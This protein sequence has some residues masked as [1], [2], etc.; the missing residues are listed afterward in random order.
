M[1]D[2]YKNHDI[3]AYAGWVSDD[4]E[5]LSCTSGGIASALSRKMI[6]NGG[7]VAGVTYT[8]G[9]YKA[10]YEIVNDESQ[11]YKF[12]SSKYV[13][14]DKGNI[15]QQ[16]KKLV[17][18]NKK[19][20]FFG[21][22]CVNAALR[23]VLGREYENLIVVDLICHGPVRSE[24]HKDFIASLEKKYKSKIVNF[25]TRKKR[26]ERLPFYLRAE[27]E[28]GK[29]Y[30]KKFYQSV[31]GY[32]CRLS[33]LHQCY[34]CKFRG[35]NRTGDIMIGDFW[36]ALKEDEFFNIKGVSAILVHTQKGHDFLKSSDEINLFETTFERIVTKNLVVV[37]PRVKHP[38]TD[39]F[40]QLYK[41]R[42]LNY[43]AKHSKGIKTKLKLLRY[44][45]FIKPIPERWVF[46]VQKCYRLIKKKLHLS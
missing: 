4:K 12:K 17:E 10:G 20:L 18:D 15:Y 39:K 11:L 26:G 23:K 30:E 44:Y 9:F 34:S 24:I 38:D 19:V 1:F 14:V 22:P 13:E 33:G 41:K 25:T 21:L 36:G 3:A 29:F 40:E 28:N 31:Y 37:N 45:L 2:E 27:F 43:A 16:V 8:D 46:K 42:G 6:Q 5:L 7:Y 35:N 32:A